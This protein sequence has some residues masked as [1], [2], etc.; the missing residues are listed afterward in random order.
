LHWWSGDRA[1]IYFMPVYIELQV[2]QEYDIPVARDQD[3]ATSFHHSV[4][5]GSSNYT[6]H[7]LLIQMATWHG[8]TSLDVPA[9]AAYQ[10]VEKRW[11]YE[12]RAAAVLDPA[13]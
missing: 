13:S 1:G 12:L 10:S 7:G 6:S 3:I 4:T 2:D 5:A 11:M 9:V 8:S